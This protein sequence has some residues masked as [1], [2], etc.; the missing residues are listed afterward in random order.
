MTKKE[1]GHDYFLKNKDELLRKQHEYYLKNANKIKEQKHQYYENNIEKKKEYG[2]LSYAKN[3]VKARKS[4]RQY[5]IANPESTKEAV[6]IWRS[7]HKDRVKELNDRW[8]KAHPYQR[9]VNNLRSRVRDAMSGKSR[10]IHTRELIGC[11]NEQLVDHI[12]SLF[13][14]E[15]TLENY[16]EWHIDH[17]RPCAS[18]DLFDESQ[19]REC[20]HYTNLQ[21]LWAIDNLKKGKK[22]ESVYRKDNR[23]A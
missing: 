2:R 8:I 14:P 13:Q 11:S 20:F 16:G 21:P 7:K 15:M 3:P 10:T 1:Y 4:V 5:C 23:R 6:R 12:V 18:F 17:I 19:Q 9:F 22:H